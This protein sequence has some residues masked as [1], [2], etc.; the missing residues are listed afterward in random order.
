MKARAVCATGLVLAA[1]MWLAPLRLGASD[2]PTNQE[3]M[4]SAHRD[5]IAAGMPR[6][7]ERIQDLPAYGVSSDG[8]VNVHSYAFTSSYSTDLILDDGNGYR[9]YAPNPVSRFMAAPVQLPSGV[10]IQVVGISGC[11]ASPGDLVVELFDNLSEGQGSGGGT[12]IATFNTPDTGCVFE[13]VG[14]FPYYL[15]PQNGGHT[16]YAVI[17]WAGNHFDGSTK[18][19]NF[20]ITYQREVS[21]AP[22]TPTFA[23]VPASDSGF[24]F[25]E[26]LAASG[27]TGGC[28]NGN[29]CPNANVT[30]RQ[31]AVFLAKALGLHWP[32]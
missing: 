8:V 18:F 28:G 4:I 1:S 12:N 6:Q 31:M 5:W 16:L 21:P 29:F 27:I 3:R 25:I 13:G 11:I 20:Y 22:A 15:Y 9:Y 2:P 24:Q 14:L 32:F 30:R 17:Y 10:Q 23:D 7:A 26:A 19:N